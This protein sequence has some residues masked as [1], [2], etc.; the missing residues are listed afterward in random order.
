MEK[1]T[2]LLFARNIDTADYNQKTITKTNEL[3]CWRTM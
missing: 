3:R 2:Q 1:K